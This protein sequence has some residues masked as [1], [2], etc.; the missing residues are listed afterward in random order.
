MKRITVLLCLLIIFVSTGVF[1]AASVDAKLVVQPVEAVKKGDSLSFQFVLDLP[2]GGGAIESAAV[3]MLMDQK[4][5]VGNAKF[6]QG[7]FDQE[8]YQIR[9]T[10]SSNNRTFINLVIHK[11][12]FEG[13]QLV[14]SIPTTARE[15]IGSLDELKSSFVLSYVV[16][17]KEHS[18]QKTMEVA[19]L[20]PVEGEEEPPEEPQAVVQDGVKIDPVEAYATE[21]TGRGPKGA[22]LAIYREQTLIGLGKVDDGGNF[23]ILINPQGAGAVL[24]FDFTLDEERWVVETTVGTTQDIPTTPEV[25][26]LDELADFVDYLASIDP[27]GLDQEGSLQLDAAIYNG[28]YILV[29]GEKSAEEVSRSLKQAR[30]AYDDL[31][32]P[33]MN[34]YPDGS[35]G[36][37][38][39]MTRGEMAAVFTKIALKGKAPAGYASF[40]DV[41][42]KAWYAPAVAY[43][44]SEGLMSGYPDGTFRPD[45]SITRGEFA[46]ILAKYKKISGK[47]HPFKD[48]KGHWAEA[49]IAGVS[50]KGY[51][52]G[53][54][55][56][57]FVPGE[58]ILRQEVATA[59][60]KALNRKPNENYLEEYGKN[61]FSDVSSKSWAY[62]EILEATGQ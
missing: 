40:K 45:Q 9:A 51:M 58:K 21:L 27:R 50:E 4:L 26:G 11:F 39:S 19:P 52:N 22:R 12:S 42:D 5:T 29:K 54:S 8:D 43:M 60:N 56:D 30:A 10:Q 41:K 38:K 34:G 1:A 16:D 18:V 59:L 14:L 20:S 61:P 55:K 31:R 13:K 7:G 2:Q 25:E 53:R 46:V 15:D 6:T 32:P 33:F 28:R 49:A 17:G 57:S 47:S 37:Q 23:R 48:V 62:Y 35:F 44:E 3:S 24:R 36:P